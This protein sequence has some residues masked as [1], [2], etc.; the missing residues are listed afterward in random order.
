MYKVGF[1]ESGKVI[2]KLFSS[3][4]LAERFLIDKGY[5]FVQSSR[6]FDSYV[7]DKKN[8]LIMSPEQYLIKVK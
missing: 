3:K 6:L 1:R 7:N 8:A 5:K 2:T 4:E